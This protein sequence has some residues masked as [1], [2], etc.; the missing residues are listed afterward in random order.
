MSLRLMSVAKV[1]YAKIK[2]VSVRMKLIVKRK[3]ESYVN[4][5]VMK[6][7]VKCP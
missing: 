2:N 5:V 6:K 1:L 4:K 7:V 3:K